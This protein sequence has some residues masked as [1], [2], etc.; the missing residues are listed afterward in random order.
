MNKI[1]TVFTIILLILVIPSVSAQQVNIAEKA[2]QKSVIVT[3]N[4]T[5]DIHVDT[6]CWFFKF[7]KTSRVD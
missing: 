4:E 6:H 3:I 1:I 7:S 2:N 5:G